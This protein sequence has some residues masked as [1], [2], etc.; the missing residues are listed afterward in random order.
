MSALNY[1]Q[2]Y[3]IFSFASSTLF[4]ERQFDTYV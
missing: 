3:A 1:Q 2:N 4:I